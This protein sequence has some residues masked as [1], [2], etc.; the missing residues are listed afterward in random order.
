MAVAARRTRSMSERAARRPG[1][2][3]DVIGSAPLVGRGERR[4]PGEGGVFEMRTGWRA[5]PSLS[6]RP[7]TMAEYE[8]GARPFGPLVSGAPLRHPGRRPRA[9]ADRQSLLAEPRQPGLE[10]RVS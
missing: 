5:E 10:R 4:S 3:R 8:R 1:S 9:G 2:R 7:A 6:P